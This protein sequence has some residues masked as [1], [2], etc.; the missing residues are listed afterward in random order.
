MFSKIL[1]CLY[2]LLAYALATLSLLYL[3][4]FLVNVGVPKGI[5]DGAIVPAWQ[6]IGIDV[7]LVLGFGLHHSLTARRSF[8]IWWTTIIPA[9]IERAT[10]LYMTACMTGIMVYF[11]QPL[12]QTIWLVESVSGARCILGGYLLVW[13]W[14]VAATF[15]FGHFEFFGLAQV[16]RNLRG[17]QQDNPT[18]SVRYLYALI[19]HPISV[20]WMLMPLVT[21]HLTL[22]HIVFAGATVLYIVL[23]TP[24]EEADLIAEIGEPYQQYQLQVP[25]FLPGG[26]GKKL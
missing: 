11:W 8:K 14:M 12:P 5:S 18:M 10:Y 17:Q 20:G 1:M 19:R 6:A 23:A 25:K 16:W 15:H 24:F 9:P 21:P 4:G 2:A 26:S 13:L 7:V 3:M 22:G